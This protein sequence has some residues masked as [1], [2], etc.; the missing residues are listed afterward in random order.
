MCVENS[1]SQSPGGFETP[2]PPSD[3]GAEVESLAGSGDAMGD[4]MARAGMDPTS[5]MGRAVSS[6]GTA[7]GFPPQNALSS[8]GRAAAMGHPVLGGALTILGDMFNK[9]DELGFKVDRSDG[10]LG[11]AGTPARQGRG[12]L[13]DRGGGIFGLS[14]DGMNLIHLASGTLVNTPEAQAVARSA[15]QPTSG[16]RSSGPGRGGREATNFASLLAEARGERLGA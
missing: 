11:P 2:T 5:T 1:P 10:R 3:P 9:L 13:S 7:F 15:Q 12:D 16:G 8:P 6:L 14:D 4:R